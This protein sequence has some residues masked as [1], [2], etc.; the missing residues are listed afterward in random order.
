M[1]R[2]GRRMGG[3]EEEGGWDRVEEGN[4]KVIIYV[5]YTL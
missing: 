1:R 5:L 3:G 2:E 4:I